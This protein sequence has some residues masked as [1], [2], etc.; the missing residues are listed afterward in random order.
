MNI[1]ISNHIRPA[2]CLTLVF[3]VLTGLIFPGVIYLVG[4]WLFPF[5]ANGSLLYTSDQKLIGSSLIG[6]NFTSS[7][8]FHSRPSAAGAGYDAAGSSGTNLGPTSSKLIKGIK[9]DPQTKDVDESY[10]GINDLAAAYRQENRLKSDTKIPAD[11]VTRSA[12][13][14]DP[15]ISP[16]NALLQTS[17]VATVRNIPEPVIRRLI[18]A[19]TK[20]RLIG[21]FGE[22]RV[23]VLELNMA[24][25]AQH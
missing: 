10:P 22:P 11:A 7:K 24:L 8:Y 13:G 9:D 15:D 20:P 4:Q 21:I 3:V 12:S 5:Q 1:P 19:N 18:E 17:R 16:A 6:Q 25:D 14:L 2:I 23:N